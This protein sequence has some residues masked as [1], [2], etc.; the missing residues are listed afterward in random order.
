MITF[1]LQHFTNDIR[2]ALK[3]VSNVIFKNTVLKKS[4]AFVFKSI[5]I[6]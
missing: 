2:E 1:W 5:R 6:R 4:D 3:T